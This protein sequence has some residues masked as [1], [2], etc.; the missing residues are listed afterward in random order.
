MMARDSD[1]R[2]V[3]ASDR[4]EPLS[5]RIAAAVDLTGI[6]RSRLYEL[7]QAGTLEI[8]KVGRMTLI[9]YES[10]KRLVEGRESD[11]PR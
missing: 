3:R 7:I 6:S 10:L 2:T 11:P 9:R 8:T 4:L 5:V 1:C